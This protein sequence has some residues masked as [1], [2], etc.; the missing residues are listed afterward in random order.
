M[1]IHIFAFETVETTRHS[2]CSFD[3][4]RSAFEEKALTNGCTDWRTYK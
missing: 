2:T 1:S 4:I 3:E